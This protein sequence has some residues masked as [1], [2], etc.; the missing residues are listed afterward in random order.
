MPRSAL[1]GALVGGIAGG[2][3]A[4]KVARDL[5]YIQSTFITNKNIDSAGEIPNNADH[6]ILQNE[7]NE[8]SKVIQVTPDGIALPPGRNI[9]D[10]LVENPF[11]SGSYGII[12]Q[13]TQK[14][15]EVLRID[16]PTPVGRK[17]PQYSHYH[18]YGSKEHYAPGYNDYWPW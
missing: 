12:D 15:F 18:I 10:N 2:Y 5:R 17:G 7:Y 4:G 13:N 8:T 6:I 3:Q 1:E 16:P 9:P 14:Y 11:R